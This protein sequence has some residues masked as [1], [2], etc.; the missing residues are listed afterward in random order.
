MDFYQMT[1]ELQ[2]L[3]EIKPYHI[4]F[5]CS[6]NKCDYSQ[7]F[8]NLIKKAE[9]KS[10]SFFISPKDYDS[11]ILD[12][13]KV[14]DSYDK[15]AFKNAVKLGNNLYKIDISLI[16]NSDITTKIAIYF[17]Y[18]KQLTDL[19]TEEIIY[20][21]QFLNLDNCK[22]MM[23]YEDFQD[24]TNKI[25]PFCVNYLNNSQLLKDITQEN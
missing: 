17:L 14:Y 24:L 7:L 10:T 21:L 18:N 19:P 5:G 25:F 9:F 16:H 22:K 13:T 4:K 8:I 1:D 20:F 11:I 3:S 12:F 6:E 23:P 15:E 2:Q